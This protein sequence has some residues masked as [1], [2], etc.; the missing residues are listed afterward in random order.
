MS[1]QEVRLR[2]SALGGDGW[3]PRLSSLRDEQE[4]VWSSFGVFSECGRLRSVLLHRPGS[5]IEAVKDARAALWLDLF[6][7]PR[8]REEHDALAELYRSHGVAIYYIDDPTHRHP[9]LYFMKDTFAMTP[10]GAILSRPASRV[11]AGEERVTARSLAHLGVPIVLSVHGNGTFEGGDMMV[12]NDDLA[13]I[14]RGL[15]T[16][17][18]G[19]RQVEDMLR[20][21]GIGE[22]V[23]VPLYD[24]C[25]HLDCGLSIVDRRTAL[26][27][28]GQV[29][30]IAREAL[31]RHG[32]QTIDVSGMEEIV[33][34]MAINVVAIE[35]GLVVIPANNPRTQRLLEA[36]GVHC[37]SIDIAELMKGG[38]A[39]HCLT[40]VM[41]RERI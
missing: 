9:N 13:L 17:D 1:L 28:A 38:G 35:P 36:A 4:I 7:G 16:N 11:R 2:N 8:A 26:L 25:L 12:V 20:S 22:V 15:R 32:F 23:Q 30:S 21:V 3:S 39:V 27:D 31:A 40:G 10:E 41:Q 37:L 5:E 34:G 18:A 6:D 14:G 33:E 19:A 24:D 29:S